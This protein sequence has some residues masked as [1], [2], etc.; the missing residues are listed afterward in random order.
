MLPGVVFEVRLRNTTDQTQR[1]TVACSFPGPSPLEAGSSQYERKPERAGQFTGVTVS[2]KLAS[3]ALGVIGREKARFGGGLEA[4][5][6]IKGFYPVL[7]QCTIRTANLRPA[8]PLGDRLIVMP[9]GNVGTEWFEAP[10]PGWAGM[11]AHI[12][13]LHL[14][15]FRIAERF[16]A[17]VG[18]QP[19]IQESPFGAWGS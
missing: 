13:G 8:Y 3:Y 15:Q 10:E 16:A 6:K 9:A 18:D 11:T 2:S 5:G 14:A 4:E 12:G 17:L 1:G 19:F 7:K